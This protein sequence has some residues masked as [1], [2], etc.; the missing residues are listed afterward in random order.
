MNKEDLKTFKKRFLGC[1]LATDMAK[2]AEDLARIKQRLE[3]TGVKSDLANANL[4]LD[5]TNGKSIF[6]TQQ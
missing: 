1:I 5:K 2:H 3:I 4:L 6:D